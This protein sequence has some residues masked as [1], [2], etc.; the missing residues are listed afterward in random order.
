MV[1]SLKCYTS[2]SFMNFS[3]TLVYIMCSIH[4]LLK[5]TAQIVENI[6]LRPTII[7][8]FLLL[9]AFLQYYR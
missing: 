8:L 2:K 5:N 3:G 1:S 9:I 6:S 4:H 7:Y